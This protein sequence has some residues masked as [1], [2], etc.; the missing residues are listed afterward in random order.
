MPDADARV[1]ELIRQADDA[2]RL[3]IVE[4]DLKRN[5]RYLAGVWTVVAFSV[6]VGLFHHPLGFL[7]VLMV[8][9]VLFPLMK[10]RRRLRDRKLVLLEASTTKAP[11]TP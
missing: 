5:G 10:K 3:E 11:L 4:E 9:Q 7:G 1:A 6:G 8:P 2:E